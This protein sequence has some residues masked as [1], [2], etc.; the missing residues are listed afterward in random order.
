MLFQLTFVLRLNYQNKIKQ[1]DR[2]TH[3]HQHTHAHTPTHTPHFIA[4]KHLCNVLS[5][6]MIK[7]SIKTISSLSQDTFPNVIQKPKKKVTVYLRRPHP[8][9]Q[10][11]SESVPDLKCASSNKFLYT[12]KFLININFFALLWFLN[13]LNLPIYTLFTTIIWV[14]TCGTQFLKHRLKGGGTYRLQNSYIYYTFDKQ[15]VQIL[16]FSSNV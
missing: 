11:C 15:E 8:I 5:N 12:W 10:R 3:T 1:T 4:V 14:F 2:Q 6:N 13:P 9:F 7:K 16:H